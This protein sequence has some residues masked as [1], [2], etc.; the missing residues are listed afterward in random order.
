MSIPVICDRCR[1]TGLAGT[2]DFSNLGDL[3]EFDPVPVQPRVNGWDADAQRA[4]IALLATTGSKRRAAIALG[5]NAYGIDQLLKRPNSASFKLAV[6]RA[7][8][9]AKQQG[10]MQL[11]Q[12]LA[13]AAARNA[14]LP[15][16][17]RLRGLPPPDDDSD[18]MDDDDKAALIDNLLRKYLRKVE[19]EREARVAGQIIRADFT[20]RQVT[21]L[22][23]ALDLTA[24]H[25]GTS[26]WEV[27][28]EA[29]L[30]GHN[31]FD[32]AETP[33]S[34][35]LDAERRAVWEAAGDPPRPEHPPQ[36][37]L[38]QHDGYS[39]EPTQHIH[40]GDDRADQLA[41][42]DRQQAED[43]KAQVE[44]EASAR[45]DYEARRDSATDP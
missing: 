40:G 37:Y 15:Q 27:L 32:I 20:L 38:E 5:R 35:L 31:V 3:L 28:R 44:W 4:F 2:G 8:A 16:P 25:L 9:I 11:A 34:R 43:A 19:Q 13:D 26:A 17:S 42:R 10:S 36:R 23:I 21:F 6:D 22:E 29:R 30:D 14:Q 18:A 33:F 12:G 45:R 39:L 1:T 41:R 7:M 24:L